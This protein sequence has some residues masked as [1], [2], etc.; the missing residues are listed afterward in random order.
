MMLLDR[1]LRETLEVMQQAI[2]RTTYRG[3]PAVKNPADWWSY[4]EIVHETR[5]DAV[6]EVGNHAG[7]AL[8]GFADMR[9]DLMVVGVDID[10]GR[11]ASEVR[12]HPRILL[13][14]GDAAAVADDVRDWLAG[15]T[16]MVVEDSSHEMAQTL[17]VLRAYAPLVGVG[18]YL[19]C[20]DTI[21]R[22]GIDAGPSPGPHEAVE[23]FLAGDAR[24]ERDPSRES[25]GITWN[26]GGYLRRIS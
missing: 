22:H 1:P 14:D 19:V 4:R 20:E 5:P 16:A 6:V 13:I 11:I 9:P 26:P 2:L 7:G 23:A 8:L 3:I 15:R 21:C 24:F 17:S 18:Q 10:H 12:A 25:F